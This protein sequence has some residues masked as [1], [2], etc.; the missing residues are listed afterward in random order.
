MLSARAD[1]KREAHCCAAGTRAA[2][3]AIWAQARA[4]P[5]ASLR[6]RSSRVR[7]ISARTARSMCHLRGPERHRWAPHR[8]LTPEWSSP[9]PSLSVL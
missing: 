1:F 2:H 6:S 5:E 3:S 8:P 4:Q 7:S 9:R